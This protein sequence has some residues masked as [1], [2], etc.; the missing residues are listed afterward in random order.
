MNRRKTYGGVGMFNKRGA[1][2]NLARHSMA[3]GGALQSNLNVGNRGGGGMRRSSIMMNPIKMSKDPRPL[4]NKEWVGTQ[5][6]ALI[7]YLCQHGYESS[8]LSPKELSPPST[9]NFQ[10]ICCFLFQQIDP[11]FDIPATNFEEE[12]ISFFEKLGYPFK[13]NKSSMR[14]IAPHSWPPLL[15]AISWLIEL[16]SF[17]ESFDD[18]GLKDDEDSDDVHMNGNDDEEDIN[19]EEKGANF[20]RIF[21][22]LVAENYGLW[23]KGT[24]E[25]EAITQRVMDEFVEKTESLKQS[26]GDF[27]KANQQLITEMKRIEEDSPSILKLQD[28]RQQLIQVAEE[29][30]KVRAQREKHF[31]EQKAKHHRVDTRVSEKV[32]KIQV[33]ESKIA[34]LKEALSKQTIS[35]KDVEQMNRESAQL[36]SQNDEL[37]L[38]KQEIQRKQYDVTE[39]I[40]N[41]VKKI[42]Q[43]VLEYN[44]LGQKVEIIPISARYSFS[45][46]HALRL[47]EDVEDQR[48]NKATD[49]CN[50]D[51]EYFGNNLQ[52][53]TSHFTDKLSKA[54]VNIKSEEDR[55][56]Q[57]RYDLDIEENEV[58]Y[59]AKRLE[60]VVKRYNEE[61]KKMSELTASTAANIEQIELDMNKQSDEIEKELRDKNQEFVQTKR[62]YNKL[63][64]QCRKVE[65][66]LTSK[67]GI[68]IQKLIKH[69]GAVRSQ[70]KTV[71]KTL[72]ESLHK[73]SF[74]HV[75]EPTLHNISFNPNDT[76]VDMVENE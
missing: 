51:L 65:I 8:M 19:G 70:L 15:G 33:A 22:K 45:Q 18:D 34:E 16:L 49:L 27:E 74:Y 69:R 20:D 13:I 40:N 43:M 29:M 44:D 57:I 48:V 1:N 25:D 21:F 36:N 7:Q 55:I 62:E 24:E 38:Q 26:I 53:L 35:A 63:Q 64:E 52:K 75:Q 9:K 12:C 5:I 31:A 71:N 56:A 66:Q 72:D 30:K 6:E 60:N 61:K 76:D 37:E 39:Q 67:I 14:C 3:T 41:V 11:T 54:A 4:K 47:N 42:K 50:Q 46:D 28:T 58:E 10:Y 59:L 17:A 68:A 73:M 2:T 23:L 32:L